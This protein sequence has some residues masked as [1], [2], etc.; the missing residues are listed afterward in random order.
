MHAFIRKSLMRSRD[1][2]KSFLR[3]LPTDTD[4]VQLAKMFAEFAHEGQTDRGGSKYMG[5]VNHVAG[6]CE[7]RYGDPNLTAAAYLHDVV[8]DGGFTVSDLM[9]FFPPVV[10]KTVSLLTR[11]KS[12]DREVYIGR[13]AANLLA[14]KVK[15]VDLE[16]N[17]ELSRIS[18]PRQT[19]YERQ[20][21]YATERMKI[22]DSLID[23][24]RHMSDHE[25]ES[26]IYAE[27]YMR[28]VK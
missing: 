6:E 12:E 3:G 18:S 21:R 22:L 4:K 25:M 8:E 23:M 14:A 24:E 28:D 2:I 1:E 15:I 10:W 7:R 16:H 13:V 9:M 19:D 27:F 17:M 26:D 11:K 5:H 20:G